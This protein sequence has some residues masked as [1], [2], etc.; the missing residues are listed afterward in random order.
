MLDN[1]VAERITGKKNN[2]ESGSPR[3][4]CIVH[5]CLRRWW[6]RRRRYSY[7][8]NHAATHDGDRYIGSWNEHRVFGCRY[9]D[10]PP[11]GHYL[12]KDH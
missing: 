8:G 1:S 10:D 3:R 9:S 2:N 5:Q 12:R 4:V 7:T 11:G 6:R